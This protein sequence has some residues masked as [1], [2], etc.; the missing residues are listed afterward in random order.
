MSE[1]DDG[2]IPPPPPSFPREVP[3]EAEH[4]Y[5]EEDVDPRLVPGQQFGHPPAYHDSERLQP[6]PVSGSID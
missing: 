2:L 4:D 5:D 3:W 6:P 1:P